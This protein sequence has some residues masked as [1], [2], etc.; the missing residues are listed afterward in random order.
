MLENA[1]LKAI[2]I[3]RDTIK[4][5]PNKTLY[6]ARNKLV[7]YNISRIVVVKENKPLGIV[8]EKDIARY[9]DLQ[10]QERRLKEVALEEVMSKNLGAANTNRFKCLC[11]VDA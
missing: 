6:D 2:D 10:I 1:Q 8:T 11:K 4:L 5:E 9:L 3:S 7:R